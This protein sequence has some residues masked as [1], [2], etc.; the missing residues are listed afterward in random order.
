MSNLI[1][2]GLI[3]GLV[4]NLV[5]VPSSIFYAAPKLAVQLNKWGIVSSKAMPP[6]FVILHF[7]LGIALVW[8]FSSLKM[9]GYSFFESV[10]YS[11]LFIIGLNRLFGFGN[12]LI[13]NM[14]GPIFTAF[15]W[16]F[17]VGT[18]LGCL[19]GSFWLVRGT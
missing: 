17:C 2:S 13:G 18:Y 5:D 15:S 16:A 7:I 19:A 1:I 9:Q 4:I 6:Y 11:W 8:L 10:F 12:V 3:A 14:P